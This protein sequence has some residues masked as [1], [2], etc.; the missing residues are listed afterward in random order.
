MSDGFDTLMAELQQIASTVTDK[1][2]QEKAIKAG[3]EPIVP[4][5]QRTL[6]PFRRNSR[7]RS[8]LDQ[9]V[10]Y[11]HNEKDNTGGIGWTRAG[12]YG[13]FYEHG[14]RP[15]T[16]TR[17]RVDGRLRWKSRKP[18]GHPT[19]QRNHI[20]RAHIAEKENIPVRMIKV[21]RSEIKN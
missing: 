10:I 20:L 19:I 14:Y 2:V 15:I 6:R 8:S 21:L 17:K 4:I 7:G 12:Y 1:K 11:E 5:A 3:L 13:R 18:S 9:E 16:G